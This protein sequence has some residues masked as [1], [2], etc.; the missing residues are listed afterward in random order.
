M[1]DATLHKTAEII[2]KSQGQRYKEDAI[3]ANAAYL[4]ALEN[5][6]FGIVKTPTVVKSSESRVIR[7]A[8]FIR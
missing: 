2:Y 3:A 4:L 8:R 5:R 1:K 6:K 7:T